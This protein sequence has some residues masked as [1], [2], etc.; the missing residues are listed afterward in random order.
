MALI[1]PLQGWTP[2]SR[3]RTPIQLDTLDGIC[4]TG[5]DSSASLLSFYDIATGV[6]ADSSDAVSVPAVYLPRSGLFGSATYSLT[7]SVRISSR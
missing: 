2:D 4:H 3:D 5:L 1:S 7:T 6:N